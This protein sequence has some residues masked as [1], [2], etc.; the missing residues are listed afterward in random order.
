MVAQRG[1]LSKVS[2][3]QTQQSLSLRQT[4]DVE[5]GTILSSAP[6]QVSTTI[7]STLALF[8]RFHI[9]IH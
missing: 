5:L 9:I 6:E 8:K 2:F 1:L 4:E 3:K 7:G